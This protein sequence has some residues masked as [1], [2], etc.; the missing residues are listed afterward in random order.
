[1]LIS[2]LFEEKKLVDSKTF[3]S[4][5]PLHKEAVTDFFKI[6]EKEDS[7]NIVM[8]VEESVDKVSD[9]HNIN[10]SVIYNYIEAETDEQLG[11]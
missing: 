4:L 8:N 7:E 1:M 2:N 11:R 6:L 3:N 5:Q 10:T 9:F